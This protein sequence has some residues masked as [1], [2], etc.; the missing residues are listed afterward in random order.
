MKVSL[1]G[2]PQLHSYKQ[3]PYKARMENDCACDCGITPNSESL[4]LPPLTCPAI[5][6]LELTPVCNNRCSG[7]GN[8]FADDRSQKAPAGR[9]NSAEYGKFVAAGSPPRAC[10][11]MP[12]LSPG[13]PM[14]LEHWE[15]ILDIIAP[16]AQSLKLT[17][18]EPTLHPQFEL[19]IQAIRQRDLNFSLFSNGCWRYPKRI[20]ALLKDTAQNAG[21]LISLH[22]ADA[23]AHEAFSG[24]KG[25]FAKTIKNIRRATQAGLTVHTNAVL[26]RYN[27]H[28]VEAL[29]KLS[30]SLGA[31]CV[32]FNR[33]IGQPIA[34][35]D[36]PLPDFRQAIRE[37]D[38]IGRENGQAKFGTCIPLCL[39]ESSSSGC[40]AGTAYCAIDPWGYV[41]PCNHAPQIAGNLLA[42]SLENIWRSAAMESW[43]SLIPGQCE[44]CSAFS[45]CHGGCRAD[46]TLKKLERDPLM[47]MPLPTGVP[48]SPEAKEDMFLYELALPRLEYTFQQ[49]IFGPILIKGSDI[50]PISDKTQPIL[51]AID[52]SP[53]L[54]Q[55]QTTFGYEAIDFMGRL[56]DRGAVSLHWQPP[57]G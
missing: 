7:C 8:V 5:Y 46:A 16:H 24:V 57:S 19:I 26:T 14:P 45:T 21:L 11:K 20:I 54:R 31:E 30:Q 2:N 9:P 28:Q 3:S 35:F 29:V 25:S 37:V 18:G 50:I 34:A 55:L 33:Y 32:V 12:E 43:R 44:T 1:V 42:E 36:L 49:E 41:R 23:K 51:A 52:Q 56:Y 15:N 22:G 17:G 53:T 27:H 10:Y 48:A 39:V 38:R 6:S 13:R 47:S 40:L 4:N